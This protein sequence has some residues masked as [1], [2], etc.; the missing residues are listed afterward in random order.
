MDCIY[1][2]VLKNGEVL[3]IS[4]KIENLLELTDENIFNSTT[5][6]IL[7]NIEEKEKLNNIWFNFTSTEDLSKIV[8]SEFL[9]EIENKE[10][11]KEVIR[12]LM[13]KFYKSNPNKAE[14]KKA[15]EDLE[16]FSN[17][18]KEELKKDVNLYKDIIDTSNKYKNVLELLNETTEIDLSTLKSLMLKSNTSEEFLEKVNKNINKRNYSKAIVKYLYSNIK[19][20]KSILRRKEEPKKLISLNLSKTI[21]NSINLTNS[22]D[23]VTS[24]KSD[25]ILSEDLLIPGTKYN[26]RDIWSIIANLDNTIKVVDI[27]TKG[28]GL[29][30]EII[31]GIIFTNVDNFYSSYLTLIKL[32]STKINFE[33]NKEELFLILESDLK[34]INV[35]TKEEFSLDIFNSYFIGSIVNDEYIPPR[36]HSLLN[37]QNKLGISQSLFKYLLED[38]AFVKKD[39]LETI[40]E[41]FF[42]KL[43]TNA[44]LSTVPVQELF[45][46]NT[47]SSFIL[48]K[49]EE[50]KAESKNRS[51]YYNPNETI[52]FNEDS[53]ELNNKN[54]INFLNTLK[55]TQGLI[56]LPIDPKFPKFYL[57]I[58]VKFNGDRVI[59]RVKEPGINNKIQNFEI[60]KEVVYTTIAK[61]PQEVKVVPDIRSFENSFFLKEGQE[62]SKKVLKDTIKI[63]NEVKYVF[64]KDGKTQ[65]GIV[66]GIYGQSLKVIPKNLQVIIP[67]TPVNKYQTYNISY[68]N[69][70]GF[71]TDLDIL[72]ETNFHQIMDPDIQNMVSPG[73]Y[74][75]FKDSNFKALVLNVEN[76]VITYV[77]PNKSLENSTKISTISTINAT[78]VKSLFIVNSDIEDYSEKLAWID[79]LKMDE[80]GNLDEDFI[81]QKSWSKNNWS[82]TPDVSLAIEGDFLFKKDEEGIYRKYVV[83]KIVGEKLF[84]RALDSNYVTSENIPE[85]AYLITSQDISTN[86]FL[87]KHNAPLLSKNKK[88]GYDMPVTV[89]EDFKIEDGVL[90]KGSISITDGEGN[91]YAVKDTGK[92][93]KR[94]Y[95]KGL[96]KVNNL[97]ML[98]N[99]KS[100]LKVGVFLKLKINE[101]LVGKLFEIVDISEKN[102][103]LTYST[104]NKEGNIITLTIVKSLDYVLENLGELYA[105]HTNINFRESVKKLEG[106]KSTKTKLDEDNKLNN[107]LNFMSDQLKVVIIRDSDL[108]TKKAA[109][110][111]GE[112]HLST[113]AN[114]TNA[115]H[116]FVH[117]FLAAYKNLNPK[118]YFNIL[119]NYYLKEEKQKTINIKSLI[120]NN[121]SFEEVVVN[122]VIEAIKQ[123]TITTKNL[124]NTIYKELTGIET[125][126][127]LNT[128]FTEYFDPESSEIQYKKALLFDVNFKHYLDELLKSGQLTIKCK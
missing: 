49:P 96:F 101:K 81:I 7:N 76:G 98:T 22:L 29:S 88:E 73:N 4:S 125:D 107:L 102:V 108:G 25:I 52:L 105:S 34:K 80:E 59:A 114:Y 68:N 113:T 121:A 90:V 42:K 21:E 69:I 53:T 13:A 3:K 100:L 41:K 85:D 23:I 63:G 9:K 71:S 79:D 106:V 24:I 84:L 38:V 127:D 37:T 120:S 36:I 103:K 123:K 119:S 58:D 20:A 1:E 83:V 112:V 77:V 8:K 115:L 128:S 124:F 32:F 6:E 86:I 28:W 78:Q 118:D 50:Y 89:S 48:E 30:S 44:E 104:Y 16:A 18:V 87:P 65:S 39:I 61:E 51:I 82:M 56:K 11:R 94:Y 92:R 45:Q 99:K 110:K 54:K 2:I 122:K 5:T 33:D 91:A 14:R 72:P 95:E 10:E 75:T 62:I 55:R 60:T 67:N 27:K 66:V 46:S 31:D 57:I 19:E 70:V 126:V 40:N 43:R 26:L 109:I 17:F 35:N 47:D 12:Y 93:W 111:N 15:V 64:G 116:E 97:N 74:V 117:I